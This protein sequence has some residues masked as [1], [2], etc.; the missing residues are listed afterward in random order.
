MEDRTVRST[1]YFE[2]ALHKVPRLKAA[3]TDR[4]VSELVNDAIR[5]TLRE[6]REDLAALEERATER[7][8]SYGKLLTDLK[9]HGR[10]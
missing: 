3:S 2:Q 10:L 9:A 7:T 6:D 1:N 5:L 8:F 4:S